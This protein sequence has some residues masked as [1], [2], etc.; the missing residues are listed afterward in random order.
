M[1]E[2]NLTKPSRSDPTPLPPGSW[3]SSPA[4][5]RG[6]LGNKSRDTTPELL[7]RR[8]LHAKGYRY[9]VD[10]RVIPGGRRRADLTFAR[11]R[12]AVFVDGCFWHGCEVHYQAP[13]TNRDYWSTKLA[14]N[15]RRDA[16]TDAALADAGW[17]VLRL[18]EHEILGDVDVCTARVRA[19]LKETGSTEPNTGLKGPTA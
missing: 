11:A 10:R 8:A 19:A 15:Q 18:W 12:V 1:V 3:A 6:M 9:R 14:I 17:S 4:V 7:L 13:S 16:D 5:R 2:R